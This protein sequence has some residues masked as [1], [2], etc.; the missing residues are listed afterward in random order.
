MIIILC[1]N[2]NKTASFTTSKHSSPTAITITADDVIKENIIDAGTEA[3]Y[4]V[5]RIISSKP[6]VHTWTMCLAFRPTK[7]TIIEKNIKIGLILHCI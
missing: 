6:E 4:I 5:T 1:L 7:C 2:N 3:A